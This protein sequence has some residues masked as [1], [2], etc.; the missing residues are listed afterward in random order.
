MKAVP[1]SLCG[2]CMVPEVLGYTLV[3]A[4]IPKVEVC[5]VRDA[6]LLWTLSCLSL[7]GLLISSL[8]GPIIFMRSDLRS[9]SCSSGVNRLFRSCCRRKAQYLLLWIMFLYLS[10]TI[11][12]SLVLAGLGILVVA[13]LLKGRFSFV[14]W[15][16]ACLLG[17]R[18]SYG[19]CSGALI[20]NCK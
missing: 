5:Q 8:K 18:Q 16:K 15:I 9:Q 20:P 7:R 6:S 11:W 1:A 14:S 12:F 4:A 3:S 17:G 19:V 10:Y 2:F 13:G